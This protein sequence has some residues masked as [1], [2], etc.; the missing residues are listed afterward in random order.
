MRKG[1]SET[2]NK[3]IGFKSLKI[4]FSHRERESVENGAK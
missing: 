3:I 4:A 2:S 1:K